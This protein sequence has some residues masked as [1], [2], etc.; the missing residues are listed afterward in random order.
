MEWSRQLETINHKNPD[1]Q[2]DPEKN[3]WTGGHQLLR[4]TQ[5]NNSL[6][7]LVGACYCCYSHRLFDK[8]KRYYFKVKTLLFRKLTIPAD[9]RVQLTASVTSYQMDFTS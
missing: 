4:M 3:D 5:A 7:S 6:K 9:H 8:S 1:H 2:E